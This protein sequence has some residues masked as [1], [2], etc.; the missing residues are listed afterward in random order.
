LRTAEAENGRSALLWL[1]ENPAPAI[2]L[3][4]LMM[5]EMDGFDF[6]ETLKH[7][8]AWRD[9]PVIVMTALELTPGE[10]DRLL[11][12]VR[13]VIAKGASSNVDIATAVS[14]AVRRR[15]ARVTAKAGA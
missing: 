7:D 1:G 15:P 9:I 8:R 5:P 13:K 3:L 6:L 11:G 10:R 12:H 4:D 14:E 2:I